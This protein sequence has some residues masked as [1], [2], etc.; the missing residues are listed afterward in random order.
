[1]DIKIEKSKRL[2]ASL[3]LLI[4]L[5]LQAFAANGTTYTPM[6]NIPGFESEKTDLA[7]YIVTIYKFGIWTIGIAALLM[8]TL[9]G[10]MY[11]TSA[12]NNSSMQKAKGIISDALIGVIMALSSWLILYTI[13]PDLLKVKLPDASMGVSGSAGQLGVGNSDG[14]TGSNGSTGSSGSNGSG[15][16]A[17][18]SASSGGSTC[19]KSYDSSTGKYTCTT[20]PSG[21]C[22]GESK[23]GD[24]SQNSSFCQGASSSSSSSNS[25]DPNAGKC[26]AVQSGPCTVDNL[27]QYFGSGAETASKVCNKES[28]GNAGL[29]STTDKTADGK[30]F[31]WGLFQINLTQHK[32]GGLDCPSAFNGK[33]YSATVKNQSLYD[34][35]VA[36]ATNPT[37]NLEYASSLYK[38]SS[39]KHWNNECG[40]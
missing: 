13:N 5:P 19:C 24:C 40:S 21:G 11:V 26:T 36:A 12:G 17:S 39:W 18:G 20:S 27:K 38:S 30:T 31:S 4:L 34:Q 23:T 1:M 8:I 10:I 33:N 22:N 2:A 25:T 35:C 28:G 16:S 3:L 9:G 37:T 32:I 6:E 14:S 29:A 7:T 15:G